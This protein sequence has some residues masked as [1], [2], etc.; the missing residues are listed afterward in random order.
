[1]LLKLSLLFLLLSLP[2][3][4]TV[5]QKCA[6]QPS[7]CVSIPGITRIVQKDET[8]WRISK[9]Y[10]VDIDSIAHANNIPNT[11]SITAGQKLIIPGVTTLNPATLEKFSSSDNSD[12]TWPVKGKIVAYFREKNAGVLNKGIDILAKTQEDIHASKAGKVIFAGNVPGYGKTLILDHG[13]GFASVY[14]GASIILA[15]AGEEV[16]SGKII[17]KT[18]NPPREE[19]GA[20][21]FQI[22]KNNKPQNPLY[23]LAD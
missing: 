17:G 16:A 8:L 1:M 23:Y 11:T 19:F 22:R 18:G 12:F 4:A 2:A 13:D 10:G 15:Q 5:E 21:H 6:V 9:I 20:L 14:G 3:C 7:T